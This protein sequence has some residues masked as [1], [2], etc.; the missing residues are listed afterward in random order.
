MVV[1][2]TWLTSQIKEG[3]IRHTAYTSAIFMERHILPQIQEL[4]VSK[5][6]SPAT[7]LELDRIVKQHL[8]AQNLVSMKIWRTD[9]T[10]VYSTDRSA[11][12][13]QYPVEDA[14][15]AATQGRIETE[16]N[17]LN[18]AENAHE[19][20]LSA[21]L[22][23]V[24]APMYEPTTQRLF[25]VSEF[26]IDATTLQADLPSRY[27]KSWLVVG[28]IAIVMILLTSS[29][30]FR[31]NEIIKRQQ[32][33][34]QGQVDSLSAL[35]VENQGLGAKVE[36][37]TRDTAVIIDQYMQKISA[38]LHD[39]PAQH[40]ALAALRLNSLSDKPRQ[41]VKPKNGSGTN[42]AY[43]QNEL[44]DAMNE[45]RMIAAG[46]MM[47]ELTHLSLSEA[48]EL[49][50]VLH[51]H[52]TGTTVLRNIGELP[53]VTSIVL[54]S[55]LYRFVQEGLNNAHR[56]AA[57]MGQKLSAKM[58]GDSVVLEVSDTGPGF[59]WDLHFLESGKLGLH[60]LNNRI[61]ILGGRFE[62]ETSETA[63]THIIATVPFNIADAGPYIK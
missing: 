23:E 4:T 51:E 43:V 34:L 62:L 28:G 1:M 41:A 16:Y 15:L 13:K 14:L 6:L 9:G 61:S 10:V 5:T 3:V 21:N 22:I 29:A 50:A 40:I 17:Q 31:G 55:N 25:A 53:A 58:V 37:V 45:I 36:R 2:G 27:F 57:A 47:P 24:Y 49:A 35:L 60:S 48:L 56:H 54:K 30:V 12:G 33:E 42:L 11:I 52:R 38:E 59:A 8:I 44:K 46:L 18:A 20:S 7:I 39:G 32:R 26:Y 63:G 19:R